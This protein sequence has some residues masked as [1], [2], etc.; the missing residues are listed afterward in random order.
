M[1]RRGFIQT[2]FGIPAASAATALSAEFPKGLLKEELKT[3]LVAAVRD[4]MFCTALSAT[5]WKT[6]E[7]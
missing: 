6:T 4:G 5:V 2:L 3:P 7:K 1:K